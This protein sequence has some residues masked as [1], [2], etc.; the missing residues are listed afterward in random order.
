M[1]DEDARRLMDLYPV[2]VGAVAVGGG[3]ASQRS[4][5]MI[6]PSPRHVWASLGLDA[7]M[8]NPR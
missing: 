3:A 2:D 6:P 7:P 4:E 1:V 5:L 8:P